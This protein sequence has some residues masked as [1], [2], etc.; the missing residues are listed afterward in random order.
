MRWA[1]SQAADRPTDAL[2]AYSEFSQTELLQS[3]CL[4]GLRMGLERDVGLR[5]SC[6]SSYTSSKP[7]PG[8]R[9]SR[10]L[11]LQRAMWQCQPCSEAVIL[12]FLDLH[13]FA[14][15]LKY[16]TLHVGQACAT[17]ASLLLSVLQSCWPLI[18]AISCCKCTGHHNSL[19]QTTNPDDDMDLEPGNSADNDRVL[20]NDCPVPVVLVKHSTFLQSSRKYGKLSTGQ[21]AADVCAFIDDSTGDVGR[22]WEEHEMV[23]HLRLYPLVEHNSII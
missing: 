23:C 12:S 22:H 5:C 10:T 2:R 13:G 17:P 21:Q 14:S 1:T 20:S 8:H 15:N 16:V 4:F 7:V 18:S 9:R 6:A 3:C 11:L 19:F